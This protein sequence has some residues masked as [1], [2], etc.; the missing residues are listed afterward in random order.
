MVLLILSNLSC[1]IFRE[2][3]CLHVE[4]WLSAKYPH[5]VVIDAIQNT[6]T[7]LKWDK[8]VDTSFTISRIAKNAFIRR[9]KTRKL[10]FI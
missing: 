4:G 6:K 9:T 5:D 7:R 8:N 2:H 1:F 3:V 10:P